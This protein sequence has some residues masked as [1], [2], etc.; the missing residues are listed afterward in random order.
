M[1]EQLAKLGLT[2]NESDIFLFLLKHPNTTTGPIIKSTGIAN[3]RVYVSLDSLKEKGLVTYTVQK[4]GTHYSAV[5]PQAL[6]EKEE[7]R[8]SEIRKLIPMLEGIQAESAQTATA[9]Y[10]GFDG[11]RTA[12]RRIVEDTPRG[13]IIKIIGFAEQDYAFGS[14]RT[15][16]KNISLKSA[17]KKQT[18]KILLDKDN[19]Q[20]K[21]LQKE[22]HTV[23]RFLPKGY[24]S[25][26]AM[27][28]L[29]DSVYIFLW[30]KEPYCFMIQNKRIAQS[31]QQY[32]DVL[33]SIAKK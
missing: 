10:E 6:L 17:Q 4:D 2:A 7:E 31:F 25:P 1:K 20:A 28:I 23:L 29:D 19:P 14:L 12:F 22:K 5:K 24:V 21:D 27:D 33:W 30:D 26:S 9:V 18:L 3:S 8:Q 32:F 13:G 15:F 11:F 16:L